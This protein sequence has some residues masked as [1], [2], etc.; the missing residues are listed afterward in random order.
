[1]PEKS[2]AIEAGGAN[3]LVVAWRGGYKD[4]AVSFDGQGVASFDGPKELKEAQRVA[5]P[6]GSTLEVQV[7]SPFLFPELLLTRDGESVP[8]SAGDPA[9]RHAAAW[10]MLAA[11]AGL[12]VVIGLLVEATDAGFLRAIGAGWPS[13]VAGLVYGG[14]A[15]LV[16][17]RS[18]LALGIAVCL[19]VLDGVFVLVAATQAGGSPPV[20]GLVARA[21]FLVPMLRGFP[22]M[23]EL[24]RPRR[25]RAAPRGPGRA[26]APPA[27]ARPVPPVSARPAP[28]ARVLSGDA[29]RQRLQLTERLDTG[30][31]PTVIGRGSISMKGQASV[32]AAAAALRFLAHKCEVGEAGLKVTTREGHVHP[33]DWSAIGRVVVRQLPPDPPWDA[34]LLLDLVVYREGRWEPFRLFTTT[35]VNFAALGGEPSTSRLENL[36][37][38]GRH[39]RSRNPG[40]AMDPETT[41]FVDGTRPPLR[42]A[43]TT[44]LA[45]YDSVYGA[46]PSA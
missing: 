2:F 10:Q 19:F 44:E 41:A 11:V 39:V 42:F 13:V 3:R 18:L 33:V 6:D 30:P 28:A 14:L 8:G 43:S 26:A 16:R 24:T 38:L 29:E 46:P 4:V 23:R 35:L 37:R 36:R 9:V 20:G 34:G 1:V 5:L 25:R 12:N 40:V 7:A 27:A 15:W 22:A 45:Q 31:A 21:F 32:D 17:G